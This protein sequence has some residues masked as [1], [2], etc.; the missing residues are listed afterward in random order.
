MQDQFLQLC[1]ILLGACNQ[2]LNRQKSKLLKGAC[3]DHKNSY[4][5]LIIIL[6]FHALIPCHLEENVKN[7]P[8]LLIT[9]V[10][11]I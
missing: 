1:V 10:T 8:I 7:V 3:S 6:K 4:I 9:V 2:L 5:F 11:T